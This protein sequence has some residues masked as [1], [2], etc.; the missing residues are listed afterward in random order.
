M[1]AVRAIHPHVRTVDSRQTIQC[2]GPGPDEAHFLH[3]VPLR[4][5][6]RGQL[7]VRRVCVVGVGPSAARDEQRLWPLWI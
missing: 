1:G 7:R 6:G 3:G 4:G 2:V 5:R